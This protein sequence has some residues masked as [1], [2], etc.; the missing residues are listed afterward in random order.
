MA[1]VARRRLDAELVRR[2]MARSRE[3]AAQLIAAGRVTVGGT[4]ATKPATQVETSA[5]RGGRKGRGRPPGGGPGG[6][7][8]GRGRAAR[9]RRG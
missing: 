3:H 4:T 8:H 6:P 1:G 2:S 7:H 9:G 5:A